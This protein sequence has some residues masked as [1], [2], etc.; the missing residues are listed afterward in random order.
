M[1]NLHNSSFHFDNDTPWF[2]YECTIELDADNRRVALFLLYLLLFM[3]GLAENTV[4]VWINWRRRHSPSA[5]LFCVLNV[6]ISDLMVVLVMPFF[7]LEVMLDKVW[8]WGRFL[9]KVTHLVYVVNFYSSSFFLAH[10]TLERYLALTRPASRTWG[11]ADKQRR[12]FL[13]AGLWTLS[14]V[15]ALV[16]NV[17][18]DLLEWNEPGCYM[19]PEY[20]Y[21]EWFAAI[22]FL[23]LIFQFLGPAAIIITCNVLIA[24]A[25]RSAPDVQQGRR[26][27][28]LV[29]V[30]SLVFVVCWLPHHLVMF[31]LMVDDL[32]PR[33]FSCNMVEVLYFSFSVVQAISLAHCVANPILYNF[34][35][36]SFRASFINAMLQYIPREA[37]EARDH[38]NA[39]EGGAG[40]APGKERKVSDASTSHSDVVS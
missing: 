28:W 12:A 33:L 22:T 6:S 37:G 15:L 32:D 16:E 10:M 7:M 14:L 31:L 19:L 17:H 34:L 25:V 38:G 2:I 30:Y 26:D 27:I 18:V 9:C 29:H 40:A 23:C 20:S 13:C 11:P 21:A 8:L 36:K 39:V 4:V 3:V 1:D 24:R 5:V 35:S